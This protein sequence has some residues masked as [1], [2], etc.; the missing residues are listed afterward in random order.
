MVYRSAGSYPEEK[1][2]WIPPRRKFR[3]GDMCKRANH[4]SRHWPLTLVY[5]VRLPDPTPKKNRLSALCCFAAGGNKGRLGKRVTI[6]GIQGSFFPGDF[7]LNNPL[8]R[9]YIGGVV[10][11]LSFWRESLERPVRLVPSAGL[12]LYRIAVLLNGKRRGSWLVTCGSLQ[13]LEL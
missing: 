11:R 4:K 7:C 8:P 12:T 9:S 13:V 10:F 1:S 3:V 2:G 6:K 5:L